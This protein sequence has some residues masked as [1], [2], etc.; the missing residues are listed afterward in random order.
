MKAKDICRKWAGYNDGYNNAPAETIRQQGLDAEATE[1]MGQYLI[2]D[3]GTQA[4]FNVKLL[5]EELGLEPGGLNPIITMLNSF[6][7]VSPSN[8]HSAIYAAFILG[9][10]AMDRKYEHL[11]SKVM[12]VPQ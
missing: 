4:K 12:V 5:E 10:W 3:T 11:E 1:F 7:Q 2:D 9:L 6:G 8:N